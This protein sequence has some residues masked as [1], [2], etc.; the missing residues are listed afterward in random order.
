MS[1]KPMDFEVVW[2]D[3]SEDFRPSKKGNLV[4]CP[5]VEVQPIRRQSLTAAL[6]YAGNQMRMHPTA[7]GFYVRR[8]R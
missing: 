4:L 6:I 5:I 2:I 7:R 1:L 3:E 8:K